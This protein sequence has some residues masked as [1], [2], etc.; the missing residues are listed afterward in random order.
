MNNLPIWN[1]PGTAPAFNDMESLTAIEA[2]AKVYAA[3]RQ[4]IDENAEFRNSVTAEIE[5]FKNGESKSREEF[6]KRI[7]CIV[8]QYTENIYEK[9]KNQDA[10]IES[11]IGTL[12]DVTE[13]IVNSW[14]AEHPE[15]TT[16]VQDGSLE[17]IK[18]T[19]A[20]KLK[21]VKD[22]VTPQMFG[23][24]GDGVA[25]DTAAI[26]NAVNSGMNVHIPKGEYIVTAPI[27]VDK[28]GAKIFGEKNS[29]IKKT[30]ATTTGE[31][32]FTVNGEE[33]TFEVDSIFVIAPPKNSVDVT[34]GDVLI[35][36]LYLT[37][38]RGENSYLIYA[39]NIYASEIS[40]I[41]TWRTGHGIYLEYCWGCKIN[42]C[43][44]FGVDAGALKFF[45]ANSTFVE[46]CFTSS[47]AYK[48]FDA[49][50]SNIICSLCSFDTGII[51][52]ENTRCSMYSIR[53]E[54]ANHILYARNSN[55]TMSGCDFERH[56]DSASN[57][58]E[59][60]FSL[61]NSH[62]YIDASNYRFENYS[63]DETW[64][65]VPIW[66]VDENSKLKI[67]INTVTA[68]ENVPMGN[69]VVDFTDLSKMKSKNEHIYM[70][71]EYLNSEYCNGSVESIRCG[72]V[73]TVRLKLNVTTVTPSGAILCTLPFLPAIHTNFLIS[74]ETEN[75]IT[76]LLLISGENGN[77]ILGECPLQVG[78][79]YSSVTYV[80]KQ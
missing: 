41:E 64:E 24:K 58:N 44:L 65:S 25:D 59:P 6:E 2:S 52:L 29:V 17:E 3:M 38:Y 66:R 31:Y 78:S 46:N 9:I 7:I 76:N 77:L 35:K 34:L 16:T 45:R 51:Y 5:A 20:L 72:D 21:T 62:G 15:A 61:E 32:S 55:F 53:T 79:Y 56:Q 19:D 10:V 73:V 14:L 74:T 11:L 37:G 42:H 63:G 28:P 57:K 80:A 27:I 18:F 33:T 13:R 40:G 50:N 1:Y 8:N 23:A 54:S 30:N 48:I 60:T 4:L 12:P 71:S 47:N 39:S 68:P 75:I 26:Q 70:G 69:G 43:N 49:V 36:D 67:T 22:Y